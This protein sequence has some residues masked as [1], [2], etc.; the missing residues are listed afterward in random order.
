[1]ICALFLGRRIGKM[2]RIGDDGV[3][4]FRC[5]YFENKAFAVFTAVK[6]IDLLSGVFDHNSTNVGLL[7]GMV[8][9]HTVLADSL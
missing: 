1:M 6:Q 5:T 9:D 3:D 8:G 2:F 4:V 7:L